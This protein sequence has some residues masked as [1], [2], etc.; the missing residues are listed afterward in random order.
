MEGPRSNPA[1][2]DAPSR[3]GDVLRLGVLLLLAALLH[4]LL[5]GRTEMLARDG[6]CFVRYALLLEQRPWAEV[7]AHNHQHPLY[8]FAVLALSQPVRHFLGT[9][10]ESLRLSAQLAAAVA[11]TLLV[12]PMYFLGRS[13]FDRRVGFW[14]ALLFQ[15]LPV[16]ARVT[17]DTLSDGLCL[18]LGASALCLGVRGLRKP[19]A[20]WFAACGLC[21][22]LA[23]LT[24][25][26]GLLPAVA[27]G[28]VL[29]GMQAIRVCRQSWQCVALCGASLAVGAL[30][31]GGPFVAVT[32]RISNK[33]TARSILHGGHQARDVQTTAGPLLAMT[34]AGP[35]GQGPSLSWGLWALTSET[36]RAYQYLAWLPALLGLWWFRVRLGR[37]PGAWALL[38][39]CLLLAA[40]LVRMSAVAGYLSERHVQ[41]LV[42][43]GCFPAAAALAGVG[44]WLALRS[45]RGWL[46][47]ALLVVAT[48]FALPILARP[49]HANQVGHRTAGLWLAAHVRAGDEIIDSDTYAS[50]YAGRF[51]PEEDVPASGAVPYLVLEEPHRMPLMPDVQRRAEQIV[52]Q[53][54]VVFRCPAA[55]GRGKGREIIIYAG[56]P[57]SYVPSPH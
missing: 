42:L 39:L 6:V 53:G 22:G 27:V 12:V 56:R 51:L 55:T 23:Y 49:L 5:V 47:T 31:V 43:C 4:G 16:T 20:G 18:F 13:L 36:L 45:G 17:S 9:N 35:Q 28:L 2:G 57:L 50:F 21:G 3:R 54:T 38:V 14:A 44:D 29:L 30:V 10:C 37:Q 11:G 48:G 26:E 24:R 40:V 34:W 33:P 25:P 46:A 52:S 7:V 15:C 19:A 1:C 32:G 8:P 41:F